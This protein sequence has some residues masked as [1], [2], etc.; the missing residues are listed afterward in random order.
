[1]AATVMYVNRMFRDDEVSDHVGAISKLRGFEVEFEVYGTAYWDGEDRHFLVSGNAETIH[2]YIVSLIKRGFHP[3]TPQVHRERL[4]VPAGWDDEVEKQV[5]LDCCVMLRDRY[6]ERLWIEAAAVSQGRF[7][8]AGTPILDEWRDELEGTFDADRLNLFA[9][10]TDLLYLRQSLSPYNYARFARWVEDEKGCLAPELGKRDIFSKEIYGFAYRTAGGP[11]KVV[12]D[13]VRKIAS[14][15]R[16]RILEQMDSVVTPIV[17][18]KCWYNRT[19][20]LADCRRDFKAR[21]EVLFDDDAFELLER[22]SALPVAVDSMRYLDVLGHL[23]GEHN[24][25]AL[26]AWEAWGRQWGIL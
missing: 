7:N 6:P 16:K 26:S 15:R 3:L 22:I 10:L 12:I 9:T 2:G 5:K 13:S 20:R 14:D 21:L 17:R 4:F 1:M 11:T 23:Q 8:D 24:A 25:A 18:D 19:Y